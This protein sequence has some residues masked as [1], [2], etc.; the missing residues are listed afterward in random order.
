M[1]YDGIWSVATTTTTTGGRTTVWSSLSAETIFAESLHT[2]KACCGEQGY[3]SHRSRRALY[4]CLPRGQN[5]LYTASNTAPS[6]EVDYRNLVS[7]RGVVNVFFRNA[8][9]F[10][11]RLSAPPSAQYVMDLIG[12][13]S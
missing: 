2:L 6:K 1:G 10:P 5:Y 3:N 11:S 9:A 12:K 4:S 7:N 13:A 8:H